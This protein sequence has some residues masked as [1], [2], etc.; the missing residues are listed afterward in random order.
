MKEDWSVT[1][2]I[3]SQIGAW[4]YEIAGTCKIAPGSLE[5][6]LEVGDINMLTIQKHVA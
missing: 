5:E 1:H 4:R 6:D 2:R 3:R